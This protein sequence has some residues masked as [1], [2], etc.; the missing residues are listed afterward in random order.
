MPSFFPSQLINITAS[1]QCTVGTRGP[2]PGTKVRP[3][4]DADHISPSS[5]EV[6]NE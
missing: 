4:H 6:D 3:G 5:A 2:F 1:G